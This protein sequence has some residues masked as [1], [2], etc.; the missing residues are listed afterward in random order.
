LA[1]E[2]KRGVYATVIF[3]NL[4][5]LEANEKETLLIEYILLFVAHLTGCLQTNI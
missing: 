2:L 1:E 5:E 4:D 3:S